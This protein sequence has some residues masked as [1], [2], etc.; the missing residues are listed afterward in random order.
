MVQEAEPLVSIGDHDNGWR[1]R[2]FKV[3]QEDGSLHAPDLSQVTAEEEARINEF[4]ANLFDIIPDPGDDAATLLC[5]RFDSSPQLL[6]G[7]TLKRVL[8]YA[9][10][11]YSRE[12]SKLLSG[13]PRVDVDAQVETMFSWLRFKQLS[14]FII[15]GMNSGS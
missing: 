5:E 14:N 9:A 13:D 1:R 8:N 11:R 3:L 2:T 6:R 7:I 10:D 15:E 4:Y 12:V